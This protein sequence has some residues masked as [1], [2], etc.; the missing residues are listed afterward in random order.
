MHSPVAAN[1]NIGLAVSMVELS[2]RCHIGLHGMQQRI[3]AL[4]RSITGL[5][6]IAIATWLL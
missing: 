1:G 4:G 2:A 5:Q 3:D 6:A